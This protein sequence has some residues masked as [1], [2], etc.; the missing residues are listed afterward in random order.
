MKLSLALTTAA[1][2]VGCVVLANILTEHL[3]KVGIS[4]T[5]AGI[6]GLEGWRRAV[7]RQPVNAEGA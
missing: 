1:A 6:V 7:L 3:G 4:W 5:V 2:Y